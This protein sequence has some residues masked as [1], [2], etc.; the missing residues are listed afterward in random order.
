MFSISKR[1]NLRKSVFFLIFP[2]IMVALLLFTTI[3]FNAR[4][5]AENTPSIM[6]TQNTGSP[7]INNSGSAPNSPNAEHQINASVVN[8]QDIKAYILKDE[9]IESVKL[10]YEDPVGS[11]QFKPTDSAKGILGNTRMK[12]AITMKNLPH[13]EVA[14]ND[15]TVATE[16]PNIFAG[17]SPP[18]DYKT[19]EKFNK[20]VENGIEIGTVDTPADTN[21][22]TIKFDKQWVDSQE[23]LYDES[24]DPAA[25]TFNLYAVP[26][27]NVI[28]GG[29]VKTSI[30]GSDININF[31]DDLKSKYGKIQTTKSNPVLREDNGNFYLDYELKVK[32]ESNPVPD[33]KV[34][35]SFSNQ[36][37]FA[38]ILSENVNTS[39]QGN[40]I[41]WNVGDMNA[42]EEKSLKYSLKIKNTDIL[43]PYVNT[44]DT[45][46]KTYKRDSDTV[47][48]TPKSNVRI[49]KK[50][51]NVI[52]NN[53]GTYT[54]HYTLD[55]TSE[56][57][58]PLKNVKLVSNVDKDYTQYTNINGGSNTSVNG[59]TL[60]TYIDSLQKNEH[61]QITY[62]LIVS[63]EIFTKYGNQRINIKDNTTATSNTNKQIGRYTVNRDIGQKLWDTKR[64]EIT[65]SDQTIT[66][67][68]G[69]F[70]VPAG[71]VKYTVQVNIT[72]DFD[73]STLSFIDR[74]GSDYLVY[75]GYLKIDQT[76]TNN[77]VTTRYINIDGKNNFTTSPQNIGLPGG[78]YKYTLTYYAK[79]Q[80]VDNIAKV[81]V[82]NSFRLDG[83]VIGK[84]GTYS[85][86]PFNT[87]VTTEISGGLDYST[88][89]KFWYF[90]KNDSDSTYTHGTIYWTIEITGKRIP[91]SIYFRDLIGNT[92]NQRLQIEDGIS[93]YKV[94]SD[95]TFS[96]YKDGNSVTTVDELKK[97]ILYTYSGVNV[98]NIITDV[99]KTAEYSYNGSGDN[100][101]IRFNNLVINDGEKILILV[102]TNPYKNLSSKES[103]MQ[104]TNTIYSG[105][106]YN[107]LS[108]PSRDQR[109]IF[110]NEKIYKEFRAYG[111]YDG[112]TVTNLHWGPNSVRDIYPDSQILKSINAPKGTYADWHIKINYE[113]NVGGSVILEDDI[114]EGLEFTYL[115]VS[116]I[117]K[118]YTAQNY[119]RITEIDNP[120]DG[121]EKITYNIPS[122]SFDSYP[123]TVYKK[124]NKI[125]FKV[126]GLIAGN[127]QYDY[128]IGFQLVTRVTDDAVMHGGQ[129]QF[130]NN[131][132]EFQNDAEIGHDSDY[133]TIQKDTLKK[134]LGNTSTSSNVYPFTLT[135]NNLSEDLD[136]NSDRLTIV[137]KLNSLTPQLDSFVVTN[138]I[139]GET[140][141][142]G[143]TDANGYI[144]SLDDSDHTQP[145]IRINV[146]D[147]TPLTIKYDTLLAFAPGVSGTIKNTASWDGYT[148]TKST[149]ITKTTEF[150]TAGSGTGGSNPHIV[151]NKMDR[152]NSSVKLKGIEFKLEEIQDSEDAGVGDGAPDK[153]GA[154]NDIVLNTYTGTT[155][156]N[157]NLTF[158]VNEHLY[159]NRIYK[160]VEVKSANGYVLEPINRYVAIA[161]A[162]TDGTYPKTFRNDV[163][164]QYNGNT[165]NVNI[166]N[167]RPNIVVHKIVNDT[168]D[169]TAHINATYNFGL[170]KLN[171]DTGRVDLSHPI[172][173]KS[174]TY[175]GE[176]SGTEK[177]AVFDN[178][179]TGT[180]YIYELDDNGNVLYND[181]NVYFSGNWHHLLYNID[182]EATNK[183]SIFPN[184]SYNGDLSIN[185]ENY[186]YTPNTVM[187]PFTGGTK[188]AV[189][190]VIITSISIFGAAIVFLILSRKRYINNTNDPDDEYYI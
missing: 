42:N 29:D 112:N 19:N 91:Q 149:T 94:P 104:V 128:A 167:R 150:R 126:D 26:N 146:P 113:G 144:L 155:D 164:V 60:T 20:I 71:S 17:V 46:S 184:L 3:F 182:G 32:T 123:I 56:S 189:V 102:K 130:I 62:D 101:N 88:K 99:S 31:E 117:H 153:D 83:N 132:K 125:K 137:D 67:D 119:P 36:S 11:E 143:S 68:N 79:P 35:D 148:E 111:D 190:V 76:D 33:V 169:G 114:P 165:L 82:T 21:I 122:G 18:Y 170:F 48:Y 108:N 156:D 161:K 22:V 142:K 69:T 185:V 186:I 66:T 30:G 115:K 87:N 105:N 57:D 157:G 162:N 116:A 15:Y 75:T 131:V 84:G 139:T 54:I 64:S 16:L 78:N 55:V 58:L 7:N 110:L 77:V 163:H 187:L 172:S 98:Y 133:V 34:I 44:A 177:T 80:N 188:T 174:I 38:Q 9:N 145:V 63:E 47:R 103:Y 154:G 136:P 141:T 59:R 61:R 92:E 90:S 109:E 97:H 81:Q 93:V 72:P 158:G 12:I 14:A 73:A 70:T 180:Y 173:T 152:T 13:E 176:I 50:A 95:L 107:D 49:V 183:I 8:I 6:R 1:K 25:R 124:G 86:N 40:Q 121:W 160:I 120:G 41:T 159:F 52:N 4:T 89:K 96:Q 23:R 151:I 53:D 175:N 134:Q 65:K 85:L 27:I 24:E 37:E 147:N 171:N 5:E 168:R 106:Y 39:V 100:F 127:K 166:T 135:V 10:Y 28:D 178:L 179:E 129:K 74:L 140:L 138:S 118:G 43:D 51:G 181:F 2:L 45:Y